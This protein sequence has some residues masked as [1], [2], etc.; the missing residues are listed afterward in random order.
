MKDTCL[1]SLAGQYQPV[2]SRQDICEIIYTHIFSINVKKDCKTIY[3]IF[4]TNIDK[5]PPE[6]INHD[7]PFKFNAHFGF[8]PWLTNLNITKR[9]Q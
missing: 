6:R 2:W 5:L 1:G 8:H 7:S 4:S 9:L 3:S